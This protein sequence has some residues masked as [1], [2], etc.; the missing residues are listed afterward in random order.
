M[1]TDEQKNKDNSDAE[2]KD[3]I[4]RRLKKEQV[5]YWEKYNEMIVKF[6]KFDEAFRKSEQE[7][8]AQIK[9]MSVQI[10]HILNKKVEALENRFK[11]VEDLENDYNKKM[12]EVI[13]KIDRILSER[14]ESDKNIKK[15]NENDGYLNTGLDNTRKELGELKKL[16]K[17]FDGALDIIKD[18]QKTLVKNDEVLDNEVE[19]IREEITSSKNMPPVHNKTLNDEI[20]RIKQEIASL[21]NTMPAYHDVKAGPKTHRHHKPTDREDIPDRK[22]GGKGVADHQ[23]ENHSDNRA[24]SSF[25]FNFFVKRFQNLSIKEGFLVSAPLA[26]AV[27]IVA[28]LVWNIGSD[29]RNKPSPGDKISSSV[30][31]TTTTI[32]IVSARYQILWEREKGYCYI[33]NDEGEEIPLLNVFPKITTFGVRPTDHFTFEELQKKFL[34]T[35]KRKKFSLTEEDVKSLTWIYLKE[36]YLFTKESLKPFIKLNIPIT[37]S[38]KKLLVKMGKTEQ[39]FEDEIKCLKDRLIRLNDD[40][41]NAHRWILNINLVCS[42]I[43]KDKII[44]IKVANWMKQEPLPIKRICKLWLQMQVGAEPLDGA[45]G[46]GTKS[47]FL[48]KFPDSPEIY[49]ELISEDWR[50]E[51]FS[52]TPIEHESELQRGESELILSSSTTTVFI[53]GSSTTTTVF[54]PIHSTPVESDMPMTEN[55]TRLLEIMKLSESTFQDEVQCIKKALI[56]DRK[57]WQMPFGEEVRIPLRHCNIASQAEIRTIIQRWMLKEYL[58]NGRLYTMWLQVHVGALPDGY[59]GHET[60][61]RFLEKFGKESH[62]VFKRLTREDW[63][64]DEDERD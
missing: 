14:D 26:I 33:K 57:V 17:D 50:H 39:Q 32:P 46:K 1:P 36:G 59:A 58:P 10:D 52:L 40:F 44:T 7:L 51:K 37:D 8:T 27:I 38:L 30:T 19:A 12:K 35:M 16:M 20:E 54:I 45:T 41:V 21:K 22:R 64:D 34:D 49:K 2:L 48:E 47:K 5:L 63:K 18:N 25:F 29:P 28:M 42:G 13:N 43:G 24:E 62:Y 55:L 56:E 4:E 53:P 15:L 6:S 61:Y 11:R 9:M 3:Y 60:K 31:T 23:G